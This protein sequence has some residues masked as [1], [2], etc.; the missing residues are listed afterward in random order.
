[1][2]VILV[3]ISCVFLNGIS[4]F[5][6]KNGISTEDPS[7]ISTSYRYQQITE[8]V[9]ST[10]NTS[11]TSTPV[12][13]VDGSVSWEGRV[14]V[15]HGGQWGTICDDRF[16]RRDAQVICSMLGYSRYGSVIAVKTGS[17]SIMLDEL[18]CTGYEN[19]IAQ[20]KS[21]GWYT[22]DCH[23]TEDVGVACNF[24][25][26]TLRYWYHTTTLGYVT[27]G[28]YGHIPIRLT[29]GN[30]GSLMLYIN[31][32]WGNVCYNSNQYAYQFNSVCRY[33]G[34][35]SAYSIS[36]YYESQ[37]AIV[38]DFICP[39]YSN[40]Y[41]VDDC[42]GR[43]FG[44]NIYCSYKLYIECDSIT[45]EESVTTP[46]Y[47][48][49]TS[50]S[51]TNVRLA[52]GNYNWEGRVEIYH[53]GAWG[54][55]CDDNFDTNEAKVICA[56]LG[57][58]RYGSVT[59]YGNAAF[60]EGYG[61]IMLDDLN[62]NGYESDISQCSPRRWNHHNCGH[63]EDA[64]VS[65]R[66]PKSGGR[67]EVTTVSYLDRAT[68]AD[69]LGRHGHLSFF[70]TNGSYGFLEIYYKGRWGYVCYN[71]N[72]QRD[73]FHSACR[74]LGYSSAYRV[75][76]QYDG[77]N[78]AIVTDFHCPNTYYY[79]SS[80]GIDDCTGSR[81]GYSN[82]CK[83][84]LYIECELDATTVGYEVTTSYVLGTH[85]HIP[86]RLTFGSQGFLQ[87]NFNGRWG[88]VCHNSSQ[89]TYQF[90]SVC[91][92]LGYS[93]ARYVYG[94]YE[95]SHTALV[96]DLQ[97][98][99]SYYYYYSSNGID[100]C[101]GDR[102][103]YNTYCNDKLYIECDSVTTEETATVP[104]K[105]GCQSVTSSPADVI[106]V[107]DESGSVGSANFDR[108]R[109]SIVDTIRHLDIRNDFIRI[110]VM[111]FDDNSRTVFNLNAYP[112]DP[113]SMVNRVMSMPYSSG[114]TDIA[115][116]LSHAC[117]NMFTSFNGDRSNAS[118]YLVLLTD[119]Q[120]RA[121]QEADQCKAG[122]TKIIS[123][124]IGDS[125]AEQVLRNLAYNYDYYLS[126]NYSDIAGFLPKLVTTAVNCGGLEST[127]AK[128]ITV[129]CQHSSWYVKVHLPPMEQQ[130]SD[131][132]ETDIY[133]GSHSCTGTRS[134]DYL[135]F[136]EDYTTCGT[137]KIASTNGVIYTNTLVYAV[138]DPNQP[139]IVH[140][141]RF[142][143]SVECD[144][145]KQESGE[146]NINNNHGNLEQQ[147]ISGVGHFVV[148]LKFF[149]D[150]NFQHEFS[151][152]PPSYMVGQNVYVKA[153]TP[154]HDYNVKMRLS[155][156]YTKPSKSASD[157]YIYYLIQNGCPAAPSA[158]VTTKST[159]ETRFHFQDFEYAF[160]PDSMYVHCNATFCQSNDYSRDCEPRCSNR[161]RVGSIDQDDEPI[162]GVGPIG[163]AEDEAT[164]FFQKGKL[165]K[166]IRKY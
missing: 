95:G 2:L 126:T 76:R 122:G 16:D 3:S 90:H 45:T 40:N 12:R 136:N 36:Q 27:V 103:G 39:G 163:Y 146:N 102:L 108:T 5:W 69:V 116:A 84:K 137:N 110:G 98:P 18:A 47:S 44:S 50:G 111:T 145:S 94:S 157:S 10:E 82:Y 132:K 93:A 41:G 141:Y 59:A 29:G 51:Y 52:G 125:V 160:H 78:Y 37:P 43:N 77:S 154:I 92:S 57:Y 118:N 68:T 127:N 147:T 99:G 150:S 83:Y 33:L 26:T 130:Y 49:E 161:K 87:I 105:T 143:V 134:G 61:S 96:T 149:S 9:N 66:Y 123:V 148:Q 4:A 131:F 80:N 54:T 31:G 113:N 64:S 159:H 89:S 25:T 48:V 30:R 142:Q 13:L 71:Y 22:N 46:L 32:R 119:G 79:S 104:F 6:F 101:T 55:I 21:N 88:Y 138:H 140:E 17:G 114:G 8:E 58:N 19:D 35:S 81:L 38:T 20:C 156:C 139:Y 107:V 23:H 165:V 117:S 135:I 86:V 7:N 11:Y 121:Q 133:L 164:V 155:D 153:T 24:K 144:M 63:S 53:N 152:F 166:E 115:D 109:T 73:Q 124:G 85:G 100:D 91:R 14:E 56:M 128:H 15:Y 72:Q 62:C 97:C 1:M 162:E 112:G 120:S 74:Y 70:L 34:Y 129:N 42:T 28:R 151:G 75:Y 65:C 158:V 60:G 67:N 106:F